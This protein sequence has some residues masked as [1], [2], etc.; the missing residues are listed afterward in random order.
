M[1]IK[2]LIFLIITLAA[3]G[4]ISIYALFNPGKIFP[5]YSSGII[6]KNSGGSGMLISECSNN[7]YLRDNADVVVVVNVERVE[8]KQEENI[9]TYSTTRVENIEKGNPGSDLI[10]V[11]TSGGCI[12]TNCMAV[13]D[14]PIL[15]ENKLVRIYLKQIDNEFSI[16][17]G[18]MGV[19]E[20][21]RI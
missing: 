5:P 11:K 4:G 14:Q 1:K 3:I 16:V 9:Y 6:V 20:T 7:S 12:G 13:E 21:G 10:V 8:V 18:I 19:E 17:C 2:N 15:H